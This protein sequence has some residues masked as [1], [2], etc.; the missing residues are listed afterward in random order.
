MPDNTTLIDV[1]NKL[2]K[3][4]LGCVLLE[5]D[6][7]EINLAITRGFHVGV[8]SIVRLNVDD[9][10]IRGNHRVASKRISFNKGDMVCSLGLNR[11][12]VALKTYI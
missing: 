7:Q 9:F 3:Q 2:Q 11:K 12:P 8:G 1:I 10:D 6:N 4:S 5:N